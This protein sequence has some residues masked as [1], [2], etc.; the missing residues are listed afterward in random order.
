VTFKLA[1][2]VSR[3][4]GRPLGRGDL[5]T[6]LAD[7]RAQEKLLEWASLQGAERRWLDRPELPLAPVVRPILAAR[8]GILAAVDARQIG[9]LLGEAG[10]GRRKPAD[11][12][13]HGVAHETLVRLGEPCEEGQELARVY[14][15]RDD[16][17]FPL[18]FAA[19]YTVADAGEA[20]EL[21]LEN[22]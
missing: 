18:R 8:S 7:G 5:E 2:E 1:E 9:L 10:A 19:C 17:D 16:P 21:V 4:V 14:L 12:I 22:L 15:R 3:L 6:A 20:P 11:A 13:D